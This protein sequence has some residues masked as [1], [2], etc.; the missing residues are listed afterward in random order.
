MNNAFEALCELASKEGWC[1]NLMCTTCGHMHFRYAFSE[2]AKGKSPLDQGWVVKSRRSPGKVLGAA[3][4]EYSEDECKIII[5]I[6]KEADLTKIALNCKFPDWLGYL[7][8]VLAHMNN[9]SDEFKALSVSWSLQLKKMV[10]IHSAIFVQ[11]NN[12]SKGRQELKWN[13]LE[14]C[15]QNMFFV[16]L[17]V[18]RLEYEWSIKKYSHSMLIEESGPYWIPMLEVVAMR[19]IKESGLPPSMREKLIRPHLTLIR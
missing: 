7:G 15:E 14:E 5:N 18:A 10:N 12:M 8:L 4:R 13:Y 11:L 2:M 6:C 3:P 19:K 17:N 1:W 9:A 16:D